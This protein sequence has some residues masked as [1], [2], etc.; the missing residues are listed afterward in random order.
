M[1]DQYVTSKGFIVRRMLRSDLD[2]EMIQ[3][4]VG[5]ITFPA[6]NPSCNY[7][8]SHHFV[9]WKKQQLPNPLRQ[10]NHGLREELERL[11]ARLLLFIEDYLTK[12]TAIYP[13]RQL[14]CLPDLSLHGRQI[15]RDQEISLRFDAAD[16]NCSERKRLF[17]AF[18]RHEIMCKIQRR[19]G[20]HTSLSHAEI[21]RKMRPSEQEAIHCVHSYLK[22]LY[23]A[24]FAQ[25]GY[26]WLPDIP[27]DS[28]P[29]RTTTRLLF[30]DCFYVDADLYASEVIKYFGRYHQTSC[31]FACYGL[32]LATMF[33][34]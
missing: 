6:H 27:S 34:R 23:G 10:E 12:A 9:N 20:V 14:L 25:C 3:D 15:F 8:A 4:A 5:I 28:L 30:P 13:P 2:D 18:L 1:L 31:R 26:S 16:L 19:L 33:I 24:I 22:S 17:R 21:D 29:S 32:D 11:Y 7:L